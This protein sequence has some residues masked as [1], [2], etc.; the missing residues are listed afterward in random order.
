MLVYVQS[1]A[2]EHWQPIAALSCLH[3]YVQSLVAEHWQPTT[4]LSCLCIHTKPLQLSIGSL[5]LLFYPCVRTKPC[6]WTLAAYSC[7][8]ILVYVQNHAAEQGA[9]L[10]VQMQKRSSVFLQLSRRKRIMNTP[11]YN[12]TQSA[13]CHISVFI[14]NKMIQHTNFPQQTADCKRLATTVENHNWFATLNWWAAHGAYAHWGQTSH[15]YIMSSQ[16]TSQ[17]SSH[18][19]TTCNKSEHQL[20][21]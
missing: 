4:A 1:L 14:A 20:A 16:L 6:S 17:C 13:T 2:A 19:P 8:F 15:S 9:S 18:P 3:V 12:Y 10:V 7:S 11:F 21:W 5:Q